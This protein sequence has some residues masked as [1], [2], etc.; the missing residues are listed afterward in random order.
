MPSAA[1][2]RLPPPVASGWLAGLRRLTADP[3]TTL[4]LAIVVLMVLAAVFADVLAPYS[5]TRLAVTQK[6]EIPSSAHWLGTDQL[7]RDVL[8]RLLFGARTA[9]G[10]AVSG[11]AIA[12]ALGLL[13]G[14]AAGYGPR[15]LDGLLVLLFDS[16]N[17]IPLVMVALAIITVLGA[18]FGTLLIVIVTTSVPTYARVI[19]AQTLAL[20]SADFILAERALGAGAIRIACVHILPNVVSPLIVLASMDVPIVM[21]MEAGFSYLGLGVKPPDASWGTILNDAFVA[22]DRAPWFV[23]IAGVPLVLA[24]LGF[25]FLGEGLRD[26][27][28]PRMR[29]RGAL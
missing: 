10:I 15:W 16:L 19:R 26:L 21:M 3:M 9:L 28:D 24:T 7:G 29:Q 20:K 23:L 1:E 22:L 18:G 17:A 5:P 2:S 14:L 4:G 8:S 11:I 13:L 27:L 6:F 25:T 12:L